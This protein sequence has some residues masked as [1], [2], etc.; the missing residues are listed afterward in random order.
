MHIQLVRSV[1][2]CVDHIIAQISFS[3]VS[4]PDVSNQLVVFMSH[5]KTR[6]PLL[7]LLHVVSFIVFSCNVVVMFLH[8][9]AF[10]SNLVLISNRLFEFL[11]VH[12]LRI[13]QM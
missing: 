10:F 4:N 2:K 3:A 13:R 6:V 9:V 8:Q 7:P 5:S 12:K 11:N 1:C